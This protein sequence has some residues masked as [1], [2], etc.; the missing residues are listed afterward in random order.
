MW[1]QHQLSMDASQLGRPPRY[2]HFFRFTGVENQM[3]PLLREGYFRN[4]CENIL[5]ELDK[6]PHYSQ[7]RL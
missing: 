5:E 3:V 7:N 2:S 4:H 1:A 6:F